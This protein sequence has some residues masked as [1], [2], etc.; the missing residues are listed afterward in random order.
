M[1]GTFIE[2]LT[3]F[4]TSPAETFRKSR[5]DTL[6]SAFMYYLILLLVYVLLSTLMAMAGIN[7]FLLPNT[8][9]ASI[10]P[11]F[12]GIAMLLAGI[13]CP[14]LAGILLQIGVVVMGGTRGYVQTVKA[15]MYACSPGY[16]LG[17]IPLIGIIAI[18]WNFILEIIGIRELQEISTGKAI[19]A[20]VIGLVVILVIVVILAAVLAA[21]IFGMAGAVQHT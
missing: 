16:L 7:L 18:I 9:T 20:I 14:F 12:F 21:F 17:W 2:K 5:A 15:Y 13:L 11:V 10:S 8:T 4:L 1:S 19:G 3:G 6:G